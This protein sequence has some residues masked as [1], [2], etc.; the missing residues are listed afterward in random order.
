M[1]TLLGLAQ[2][3]S[4]AA[5][6]GALATGGALALAEKSGNPSLLAEARLAH[7]EV[8]VAAGE[9]RKG[10]ETALAAEQW[11]ERVAA[12]EQ[13][14]RSRLVAATAEAALREPAKSRESAGKAAELL[15]GLE[16]KWDSVNYVT[17]V[18]R[19][20]VQYQRSR[21]VRLAAK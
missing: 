19:P 17:Y 12:Q 8:L 2:A 15:A 7:A 11:F 4:G 18:A 14:W 5:R 13:L 10:L 16:Q 3:A 6:D 20:D 1:K 9:T 21:L